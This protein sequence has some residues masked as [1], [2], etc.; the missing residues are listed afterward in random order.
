MLFAWRVRLKKVRLKSVQFKKNI[1]LQE[2]STLCGDSC[3]SSRWLNS[4]WTRNLKFRF[5][6]PSPVLSWT[7]ISLLLEILEVRWSAMI[8]WNSTIKS[9][10]WPEK[11]ATQMINYRAQWRCFRSLNSELRWSVAV[12]LRFEIGD[13][14]KLIVGRSS[15]RH[16]SAIVIGLL[17]GFLL[18]VFLLAISKRQQS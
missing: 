13:I 3:S 7:F 8:L 15:I 2:N 10:L 1:L 6:T 14:V 9:R 17:I 12:S 5:W 4:S 18:F 11:V 16:Q